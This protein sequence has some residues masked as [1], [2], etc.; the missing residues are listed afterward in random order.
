[1]LAL[2]AG[3]GEV[4]AAVVAALD[5]PP[6]VCALDGFA[7]D[8]LDVDIGFR[9]E[10]LGSLLLDLKGRGVTRV[11]MV[12]AIRRPAVDPA[13]IDAATMP[14]VP[15]LMAAIAA[16][17]D[18]ALRAVAGIFEAAGMR[19]EAA[20][21]IAPALLPEPGC[22]TR[23][24]PAAAD[25]ADA[26]RGAEIVAAM[27]AV[28]IGQSCVVRAGQALAVEALFGTDWMLDSLRQRPDG[29]GGLLFKAPKPDQDRRVDLPT[30]GPSTVT[31]AAAAGLSGIVVES[32]GVLVLH[33]DRVV[34]ECDR[35]GLF[36]W[37]RGRDG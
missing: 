10:R 18:G 11:C 32:G 20:H 12:G 15:V 31:G 1:M 17:D 34:A 8:G 13:A 28:D 9:I 16:G 4:P 33:R 14:L 27:G 21:E 2:I 36:L 30:I 35:L 29:A 5:R 24:A 7:P 37:L 22:L 6:L 19:I 26:A 23:A 3:Q 25:R